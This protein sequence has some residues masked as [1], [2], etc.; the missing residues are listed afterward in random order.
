MA[1]VAV[2]G[3]GSEQAGS[4][5]VDLRRLFD[6][7][8]IAFVGASEDPGRNV[9]RSLQ[10]TMW[11]GFRGRIL[12][13]NPKY[14]T[15]FGHTCVADVA[16]LREPIDIV[17]AFVGPDRLLD[18]Y[19]AC[20]G[21]G[22]F[23]AVG[24][25]VPK[26]APEA[27][28]LGREILALARGGWP[29]IVGPQC[30]GIVSPE[31]G[32]AATISTA[33]DDSGLPRGP[34]GIV[35]Q[36]GGI[37]SSLI[38]RA[39]TLGGGF[40]HLVSSGGEFD[41]TT[42][43]YLRFLV[44]DPATRVIG[45]YAESVADYGALLAMGRLARERGKPVLLLQPGRSAAGAAAAQSHSGRIV[46]DRQVKDAAYRRNGI[47]TVDDIDDLL[48]GGMLLARHRPQP[49]TGVAACSLS[50][51]YAA[52]LGDR[53]VDHGLRAAA[54][55]P[56]TVARIRA[57]TNQQNPANPIDAGGRGRPR[58]GYLDVIR[59]LEILDADPDVGATIY[60][61]TLF[62]YMEDIVPVLPEF[63]RTAAKP[64]LVCWQAGPMVEPVLAQLRQGGV[65]TCREPHT[66]LS[67][68][69]TFWDVGDLP[70]AA[71]I[72]APPP[73]PVSLPPGPVDDDAARTLLARCAVPF[74]P[75]I[76]APDPEA[77]RRR[78][79]GLSFPVALKG[80]I[81][82]CL[83]KSDAGLVVLDL[84]D[85]DALAAAA[86]AMAARLPGIARFR[87]QAMVRGGIELIVGIKTDPAVG[88]AVLLGFGGIYAE[89]MGPPVVE[90]APLDRALADGMVRRLDRKGILAGYRGRR[91]ARDLLVD[92]LVA[93]GRLAAAMG[94]ALAEL[95][96]NP[97]IVTADAAVA[98]DVAMVAQAAAP[99]ASP[100]SRTG[101][102]P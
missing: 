81:P 29:R 25:V 20:R 16:D 58:A 69:R 32:A 51:G 80:E 10:A 82:G 95:D 73:A 92:L 63:A 47:V 2:H 74:V 57:E 3:P 79:P 101:R 38:E 76:A 28:R 55:S 44:D 18:V 65:L 68:L 61:E 64:H 17:M 35:S 78:A 46:G 27:E 13:V 87:A 33:V 11:A 88:A 66:A 39:R 6:P 71:A 84:A 26:G 59:T 85:A 41:L 89:A 22:F 54:L 96:L 40:S 23:I 53:I 4:A 8:T 75:E 34:I 62:S 102:T 93:V 9:A 50:G 56:P 14:E 21:A 30:V 43:D 42:P 48:L 94:P 70:R 37:V 77:L 60:A 90:L 72:E 7:R 100:T 12:P 97:V 45:I 49:G 91:L 24:D 1:R 99:P 31:T 15:V 83:H 19:R 5:G 52:A 98:V 67:A 36:S 86:A